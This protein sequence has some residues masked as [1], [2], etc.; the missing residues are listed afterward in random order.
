[1]YNACACLLWIYV[2]IVVAARIANPNPAKNEVR[3]E[4][5]KF[6]EVVSSRVNATVL[7]KEGVD[8]SKVHLSYISTREEDLT[9][10]LFLL[11]ILFL[12]VS[13]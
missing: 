11:L 2:A 13:I 7:E 5:L 1:M 12:I 8:L 9:D 10:T 4:T 6:I 3:I